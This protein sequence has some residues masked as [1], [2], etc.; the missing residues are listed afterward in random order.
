MNSR[1]KLVAIALVTL[2][3]G[4]GISH[5]RAQEPDAADLK[6]TVD[7][8]N[9]DVA[10]PKQEVVCIKEAQIGTRLKKTVCHT[11]ATTEAESAEAIRGAGNPGPV[12]TDE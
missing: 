9:T 5:T 12:S 3:T 4:M 1:Q 2:T 11:R 7:A 6:Q 8:H 10:A